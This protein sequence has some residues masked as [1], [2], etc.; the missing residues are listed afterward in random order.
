VKVFNLDTFSA[1]LEM[2]S[3]KDKTLEMEIMCETRTHFQGLARISHKIS[4]TALQNLVK[5]TG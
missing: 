3:H 2:P 5:N 1:E 4:T